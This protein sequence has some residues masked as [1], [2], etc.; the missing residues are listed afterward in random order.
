MLREKHYSV[1][2]PKQTTGADQLV[3]AKKAGNAA[4]AKGLS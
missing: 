1:R 4:G 3:R 2:V